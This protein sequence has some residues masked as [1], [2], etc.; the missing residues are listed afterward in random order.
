MEFVLAIIFFVIG[1]SLVFKTE[2]YLSAFGRI[3]FFERHLGTSGGSRLGYKLLGALL[4]LFGIL[5]LV[6]DFGDLIRW[7]LSPITKFS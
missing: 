5:A 3:A 7:I 1:G 4:V 2:A 6:G